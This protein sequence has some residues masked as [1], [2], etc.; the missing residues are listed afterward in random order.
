[1]RASDEAIRTACESLAPGIGAAALADMAVEVRILANRYLRESEQR[2]QDAE[3]ARLLH[4]GAEVA[5]ER[6]HC[7]RATI[8]RRAERAKIVARFSDSAT[9]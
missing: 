2:E 6:Q 8:Y 5:A 1:M 4:L 7:H 9:S 3:A